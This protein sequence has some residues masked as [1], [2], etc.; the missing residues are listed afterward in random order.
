VNESN[1]STV[2]KPLLKGDDVK[3]LKSSRGQL[4]FNKTHPPASIT[5]TSS[6]DELNNTFLLLLKQINPFAVNCF[7]FR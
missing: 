6:T 5:V 2:V 7:G 4:Q 1:G 3:E